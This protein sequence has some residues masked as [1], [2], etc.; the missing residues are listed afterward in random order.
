MASRR[1]QRREL[2][3][4]SRLNCFSMADEW[5]F[6]SQPSTVRG[7]KKEVFEVKAILGERKRKVREFPFIVSPWQRRTHSKT[8]SINC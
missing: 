7:P 2:G 1:E 3:F 5:S 6:L 4:F 8:S